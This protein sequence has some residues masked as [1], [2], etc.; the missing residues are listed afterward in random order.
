M[1]K[2]AG[3]VEADHHRPGTRRGWL[4]P[5]Q[6]QVLEHDSGSQSINPLKARFTPSISRS[7]V[8][9]EFWKLLCEGRGS[10]SRQ[11][12]VGAEDHPTPPKPWPRGRGLSLLGLGPRCYSPAR[13][14]RPPRPRQKGQC[15]GQRPLR[16]STV[17]AD[18]IHPYPT[19]PQCS[20]GSFSEQPFSLMNC[21]RREGQV[22][23][24]NVAENFQVAWYLGPGCH[25]KGWSKRPIQMWVSAVGVGGRGRDARDWNRKK[26]SSLG[27]TCPTLGQGH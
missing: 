10:G 12:P 2:S 3:R 23:S 7:A 26:G 4:P 24:L 19:S 21:A 27:G 1:R 13:A 16:R 25:W 15:P 6:K 17:D 14:W 5:R 18:K 22:C 11:S 9:A 20:Q 8:G